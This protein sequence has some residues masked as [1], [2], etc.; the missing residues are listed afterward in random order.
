MNRV[1]NPEMADERIIHNTLKKNLFPV[2]FLMKWKYETSGQI[3][4]T[5]DRHHRAD[6]F[7]D[8]ILIWPY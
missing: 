2:F 5:E 6:I 4:I 8:H 3:K 7:M 1:Y